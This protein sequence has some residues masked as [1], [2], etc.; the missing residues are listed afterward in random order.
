MSAT[1]SVMLDVLPWQPGAKAYSIA[2]FRAIELWLHRLR[3]SAAQFFCVT[4]GLGQ[5]IQAVD[6]PGGSSGP[7][8]FQN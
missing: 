7:P 2:Y 5:S 1:G 8:P 6:V 4:I 3:M